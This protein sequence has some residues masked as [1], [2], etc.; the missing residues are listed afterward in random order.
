MAV[1]ALCIPPIRKVRVWMG[2]RH[3]G[4]GIMCARCLKSETSGTRIVR[5][6]GDGCDLLGERGGAGGDVAERDVVDD[7]AGGVAVELDLFGSVPSLRTRRKVSLPFGLR[8]WMLLAGSAE[9]RTRVA[10]P[11]AQGRMI[12]SELQGMLE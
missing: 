12:S 9:G 5:V 10:R 2:T 3:L 11:P 8:N 4:L 7:L 1:M 6:P